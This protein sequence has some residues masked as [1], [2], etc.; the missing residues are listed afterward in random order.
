M[1]S[2]RPAS[3]TRRS[4]KLPIFL[5]LVALVLAG[6][7]GG[8]GGG[9]GGTP[10]AAPPSLASD[11]VL[12]RHRSPVTGAIVPVL[13]PAAGFEASEV[14][15]PHVVVDSSRGADKYMLF[16]EATA[17]GGT[18]TIGLAT[19]DEEDFETTT[20]RQQVI[21]LGAAGSG[22]DRGATDPCV[23]VDPAVPFGTV[24]HYRMWFEGRSGPTGELSSILYTTSG[25][26][27]TWTVPVI[28]A[29]LAADFA[30][31]R[32]ADPTVIIEGALYRMW[33]EAVDSI[34]LG[35]AD[36]PGT[37]GYA[38]SGDGVNWTVVDA[39][40]MTGL[41]ADPV[42]IPGAVGNFDGYS[43]NAPCVVFDP[44]VPAGSV[45]RY[46]LFY[47]A[48]DSATNRESSIGYSQSA[49]GLIWNDV[50]LPALLP[51]SDSI[52]PLPFDSGDLEHPT[53]VLDF[54]FMRGDVG[55][56][57]LWYTGDG[58]NGANGNRIGLAR[59]FLP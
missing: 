38:Q 51:S 35:G 30:S 44:G 43:V 12:E 56:V 19:S 23:V 59:G 2:P 47:E 3:R 45:G 8:G 20:T 13:S 15:S 29:G 32:I 9:G 21:G 1:N 6:C 40:G 39:A 14:D 27:T 57:L 10:P 4:P 54:G 18:N 52:M 34:E 16:Y 25:N 22:F 49:D 46:K 24:G 50:T 58:E 42:Y 37:I 41:A 55:F 53:A 48:I 36:G 11:I 5:G 7:G 17:S 26:G 31:L 33:F 28:C